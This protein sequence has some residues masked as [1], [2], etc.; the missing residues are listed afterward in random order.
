MNGVIRDCDFGPSLNGAVMKIGGTGGN[1]ATEGS[2]GVL[3]E[4]TRIHLHVDNAPAMLLQGANTRNVDLDVTWDRPGE[5][6]VTDGARA[7]FR[8]KPSPGRTYVSTWWPSNTFPRLMKRN[9][10]PVTNGRGAP[11]VSWL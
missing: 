9:A 10:K 5:I 1:P 11:G 6:R 8:G 2:N 3:V 4:R 7:T